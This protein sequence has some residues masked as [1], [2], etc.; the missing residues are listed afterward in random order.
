[1]ALKL[2]R[3]VI[4]RQNEGHGGDDLAVKRCRVKNARKREEQRTT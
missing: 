2:M 1:M 4:P 3:D